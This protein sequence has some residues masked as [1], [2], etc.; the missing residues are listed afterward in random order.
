M[1]KDRRKRYRMNKLR[2]LEKKADLLALKELRKRWH[3]RASDYVAL[4]LQEEEEKA[5]ENEERKRQE[6]SLKRAYIA[7]INSCIEEAEKNEKDFYD[8]KEYM[9][10]E[11]ETA[12]LSLDQIVTPISEEDHEVSCSQDSLVLRAHCKDVVKAVRKERDQALMLARQYRNEV[13][14]CREEKRELKCKLERRMEL[15]RGFWRNKIIEGGSRSGRILRAALLRNT[16]N[17]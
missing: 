1:K 14:E 12:P 3:K 8:E 9:E 15:I 4:G 10:T 6:A 17:V 7:K 16:S 11:S 13:E 2:D 5:K